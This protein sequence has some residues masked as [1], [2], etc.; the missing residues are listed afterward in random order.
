MGSDGSSAENLPRGILATL[1]K[2]ETALR[3]SHMEIISGIS[4]L[5]SQGIPK[6]VILEVVTQAVEAVSEDF[7]MRTVVQNLRRNEL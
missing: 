6:E 2:H 3:L 7:T 4:R 1:A 5:L